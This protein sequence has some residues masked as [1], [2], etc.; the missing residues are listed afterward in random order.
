AQL[1]AGFTDAAEISPWARAAV[2]LA[3]R[4]GLMRGRESNRFAPQDRSTRAEA[5][6]VLCRLLEKLPQV[7]KQA[8]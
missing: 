8:G 2:A 6:V 7:G 5:A 4:E 3:V 1:L